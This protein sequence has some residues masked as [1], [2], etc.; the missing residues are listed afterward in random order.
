MLTKPLDWNE[1]YD[2]TG[3]MIW[4]FGNG[5]F[6]SFGGR[7]SEREPP[8][9]HEIGAPYN[10][11]NESGYY[12]QLPKQRIFSY[13]SK[14]RKWSSELLPD[15]SR[16]AD[17]AYTQSTR[18]KV[19]YLFGG[20]AIPENDM[21]QTKMSFSDHDF[22]PWLDKMVAYDFKTGKPNITQLPALSM[23]DLVDDR[24]LEAYFAKGI[25][26][27]V[28]AIMHSLDRVGN[29][30]ILVTFGGATLVKPG[31]TKDSNIFKLVAVHIFA[32]GWVGS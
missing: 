32:S 5:S 25:G 19:G 17:S 7:F 15:I 6:Y 2:G 27:T 24:A 16:I 23:G 3:G 13:N 11:N 21:A 12:Y 31:D 26:K 4:N 10:T 30:G 8:D 22:G 20:Y 1:H 28:H 14:T 18:N 9:G 29:E